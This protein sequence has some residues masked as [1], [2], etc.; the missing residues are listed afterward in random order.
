MLKNF[1]RCRFS[2][3][4]SNNDCFYFWIK[5]I[6][7]IKICYNFFFIFYNFFFSDALFKLMPGLTTMLSTIFLFCQNFT[8]AWVEPV[9]RDTSRGKTR[10]FSSWIVMLVVKTYKKNKILIFA[11]PSKTL[12]LETMPIG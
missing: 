7:K 2:I 11:N 4:S 9:A 3:R 8:P 5:K 1:A 10:P 6:E 12:D